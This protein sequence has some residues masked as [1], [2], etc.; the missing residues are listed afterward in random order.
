MGTR[1]L[2]KGNVGVFL[3]SAECREREEKICIETAKQ[4]ERSKEDGACAW[5]RASPERAGD[6]VVVGP[7][8][9]RKIEERN[10]GWKI[11]VCARR[12]ETID[13]WM[14]SVMRARTASRQSAGMTELEGSVKEAV[15]GIQRTV[16]PAVRR[17]LMCHPTKEDGDGWTS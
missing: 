17:R 13:G 1:V 4:L 7:G 14:A 10:D 6:W 11:V 5:L 16:R 2:V 15:I 9:T 3:K 12:R 8:G